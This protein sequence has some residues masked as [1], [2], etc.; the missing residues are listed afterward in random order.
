M[1]SILALIGRDKELF[2]TDIQYNEAKLS[3]I[4]SA[5]RFL[6]LGGAGSI[7]QAVTSAHPETNNRLIFRK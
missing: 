3:E 6:V 1:K 5:S 7:G 2:F 4:V